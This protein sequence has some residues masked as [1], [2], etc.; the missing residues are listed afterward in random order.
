MKGT[1]TNPGVIPLTL[2]YIFEYF[3]NIQSKNKERKFESKISL[4]YIEIYNEKIN[5]LLKRGNT[6]LTLRTKLDKSL[7]I[8]DLTEAE[9]FTSDEAITYL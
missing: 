1:K 5:D 7:W 3:E 4:N 8:E 6:D 2:K 9:V